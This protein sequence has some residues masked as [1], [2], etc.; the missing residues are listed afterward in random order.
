MLPRTT[1]LEVK[2]P[3]LLSMLAN[4]AKA[5]VQKQGQLMLEKQ[6]KPTTTR[7]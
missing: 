6:V 4:K 5:L 1:R 2:L 3:W 7:S